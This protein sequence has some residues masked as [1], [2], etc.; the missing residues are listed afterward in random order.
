VTA[1]G[2]LPYTFQWLSN[3]VPIAGATNSTL[4]LGNVAA[5]GSAAYA[6]VVNNNCGPVTGAPANLTVM[7]LPT[8]LPQLSNNLLT[9]TWAGSNFLL[10]QSTNPAG[11]WRTNMAT[12]PFQ[13]NPV[14]PALFFRLQG[15]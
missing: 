12:S 2:T 4:A 13:T 9:L 8:L 10:L 11:P 5:N 7:P 6:C 3:N 15:P 14:S 1:T